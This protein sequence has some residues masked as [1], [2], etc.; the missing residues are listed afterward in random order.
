M[1]E[2]SL[3]IE[4]E[5]TKI[6]TLKITTEDKSRWRIR[7]KTKDRPVLALPLA[8]SLQN[9]DMEAGDTQVGY[10]LFPKQT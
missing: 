4:P 10:V 3:P 2:T 8:T 5:T 1:F 7:K 6:A 9:V